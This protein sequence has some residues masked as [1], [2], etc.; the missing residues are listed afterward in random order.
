MKVDLIAGS[1]SQSLQ[2]SGIVSFLFWMLFEDCIQCM[3]INSTDH[4]GHETFLIAYITLAKKNK[5][6]KK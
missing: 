3:E 5:F 4:S 1:P 2:N 6:E